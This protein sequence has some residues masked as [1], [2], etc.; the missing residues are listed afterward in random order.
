MEKIMEYRNQKLIE[1]VENSIKTTINEKR[2]VFFPKLINFMN[3]KNGVEIGVDK[4]NFSKCLV[5]G[6][7]IEKFWS[8][9]PWIDDFGSEHRPGYFDK[10]GNVRY[11]QAHS[12]LKP[13]IDSGRLSMLRFNSVDAASM[14]PDNLDFVYIDGDHSLEG[15]FYDLYTWVPKVRV[16]GIVAGHDYKNGPNS[17][18]K[19]YFGNQ[20]NYEVKTVVD[21]YCQKYGYKC[22]KVC[23]HVS[24]WMFVKV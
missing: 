20:L 19:D 16:G 2:E 18:M 14:V 13:Y 3:L 4:G 11:D 6:T 12:V 21:F 23:P 1:Y 8:I 10:S 17:G 5:E 15:I 24:S 22:F 9:D 7:T